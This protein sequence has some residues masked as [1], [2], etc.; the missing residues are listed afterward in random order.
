MSPHFGCI[1]VSFYVLGISARC[2]SIKREAL[3]RRCPMGPWGAV[4]L[5][6]RA[7]GM[8]PCGLH[9]PSFCS[10]AEIAAGTLLGGVVP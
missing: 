3:C 8:S 4:P 5:F 1:S 9:V 10:C 7:S 6:T 2:L